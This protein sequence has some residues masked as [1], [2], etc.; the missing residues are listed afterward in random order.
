MSEA[1][2]QRPNLIIVIP[3]DIA[4]IIPAVAQAK[5][6]GIPVLDTTIE[7]AAAGLK[8]AVGYVGLIDA[9]AGSDDAKLMASALKT[10]GDQGDVG[11]I[12]GPPGGSAVER[13]KGFVTELHALAPKLKVVA[14]ENSD[15]T[16]A[17]GFT[18]SSEYISRYGSKLV[19]IYSEDDTVTSGVAKAIKAQ[20]LIGKV[21]LIAINGNKLGIQCVEAKICQAD[22]LQSPV[23]DG[24]WT[25]LYAADYLEGLH[26]ARVIPLATPP[27]TLS[28]V[29]Q[30]APGW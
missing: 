8:Y 18:I 30:F 1:I 20:K 23:V 12:E 24:A 28:N 17:E 9:N 26:P 10:E 25:M 6:A 21:R 13:T 22:L 4:A 14:Q 3:V 29:K 11:V 2:A 7:F 27:I 19:G 15:L 16:A 5:A